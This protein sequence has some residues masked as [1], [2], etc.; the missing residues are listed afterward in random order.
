[1]VATILVKRIG[2]QSTSGPVRGSIP[3]NS[4]NFPEQKAR[5]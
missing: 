2:A 4:R 5:S 3:K 1:M